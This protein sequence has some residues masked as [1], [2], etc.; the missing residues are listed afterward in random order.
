MTPFFW[1]YLPYKKLAK[2]L[3]SF[4]HEYPTKNYSPKFLC[5]LFLG[6]SFT[7]PAAGS[8]RFFS[9]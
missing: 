5:L 6:L 2:N 1:K 4:F 8:H 7:W 3:P 9:K